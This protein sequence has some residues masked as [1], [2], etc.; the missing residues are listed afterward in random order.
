VGG[1]NSPSRD[2]ILLFSSQL[3]HE[4]AHNKAHPLHTTLEEIIDWKENPV[5][6]DRVCM[7]PLI[8]ALRD[9]VHK[10]YLI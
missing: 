9:I 3:H 2:L 10:K 7:G 5:N 4:D 6:I 1:Q 8:E